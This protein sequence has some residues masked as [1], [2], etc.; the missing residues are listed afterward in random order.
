[1]DFIL[2]EAHIAE[3]HI[4]IEP[5]YDIL[6]ISLSLYSLDMFAGGKKAFEVISASTMA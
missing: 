4:H 3:A 1:M 5:I 6:H 2:A